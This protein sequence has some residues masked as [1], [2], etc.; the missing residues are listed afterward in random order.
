MRV[1]SRLSFEKFL[2]LL[3]ALKK[4]LIESRSVAGTRGRKLQCCRGEMRTAG[5]KVIQ[6]FKRKNSTDIQN[7]LAVWF[8]LSELH[9]FFPQTKYYSWIDQFQCHYCWEKSKLFLRGRNSHFQ[10]YHKIVI[11]KQCLANTDSVPPRVHS[12][13]EVYCD[14]RVTAVFS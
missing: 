5:H 10:T 13:L 14:S 9:Q 8:P 7:I 12:I 6:Y 11:K 4:R 3:L 1:P 2:E